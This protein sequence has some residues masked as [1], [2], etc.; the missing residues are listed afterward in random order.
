MS[1]MNIWLFTRK[2]REYEEH[3]FRLT[4]WLFRKT[5]LHFR[6]LKRTLAKLV[7]VLC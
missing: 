3:S 1:I 6:E 5:V 2:G 7:S 4:G